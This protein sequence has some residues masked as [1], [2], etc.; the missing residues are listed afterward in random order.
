VN[1]DIARLD[2]LQS[3]ARAAGRGSRPLAG[4]YC[5]TGGFEESPVWPAR[6]PEMSMSP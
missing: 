3:Y 6:T 2:P 1:M 5:R 4:A